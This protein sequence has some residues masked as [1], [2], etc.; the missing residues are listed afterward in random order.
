MINLK[1]WTKKKDSASWNLKVIQFKR[2]TCSSSLC[3]IKTAFSR[4]ATCSS[5][6]WQRSFLRARHSRA[7][8]RLLSK[9][10]LTIKH[11]IKNKRAVLKSLN[12]CKMMYPQYVHKYLRLLTFERGEAFFHAFTISLVLL[13]STFSSVLT[14]S[15]SFS[16]DYLL[17]SLCKLFYF[18]SGR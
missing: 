6:Y 1:S 10:K 16:L 8:C 9:N 7:L 17:Y 4:C 18:T 11:T 15:S 3:N 13:L 12:Q 5:K 2:L 14:S